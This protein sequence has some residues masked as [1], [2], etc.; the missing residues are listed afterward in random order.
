MKVSKSLIANKILRGGDWPCGLAILYVAAVAG[1]ALSFA[2]RGVLE[3]PDTWSFVNAWDDS[4]SSGRIDAWRMP[5]YP[6]LIGLMKML[7]GTHFGVGVVLVQYGVFL[8]SLKYFYRFAS[9]VLCSRKMVFAA[10]LLY[11]FP[12][13]LWHSVLQT[14][15]LTMSLSVF[16]LWSAVRLRERFSAKIFAVY[17]LSTALTVFMRPASVCILPAMF[18]WWVYVG[19][20]ERRRK[21]ALWCI[22]LTVAASLS[23]GCYMKAFEREYGMLGITK[24]SLVNQLFILFD[25]DIVNLELIED[26][27][28]REDV[29]LCVERFKMP[30]GG[31]AVVEYLQSRYEPRTLNRMLTVQYGKQPRRYIEKTFQYI[32]KTKT[33]AL[34]IYGWPTMAAI[35]DILGVNVGMF[36]VFMIV[37]TLLSVAWMIYRRR[38]APKTLLLLIMSW[39]VFAFV[40]AGAQNDWKRLVFTTCL[41]VYILMACQACMVLCSV[42]RMKYIEP[43]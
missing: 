13:M 11:I 27:S 10:S 30:Y 40:I 23:L 24:I 12:F 16:I 7:L 15:S 34:Y 22:G 20:F 18:V 33:Y 43:K 14:E 36:Y 25:R 41:P 21:A 42:F 19:V 9:H 5:V 1:A 38:A 39:S 37:Y 31:Y 6:C 2:L 35:L 8:L 26:E 28:L 32:A 29:K 3:F 4:L 17:V